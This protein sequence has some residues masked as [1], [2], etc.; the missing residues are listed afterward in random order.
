MSVLKFKKPEP[1]EPHISGQAVC[2][3]CRHHWVAVAPVGSVDL[4]CPSCE[5]MRGL[6]QYPVGAAEGDNVFQCA[7]G[8]QHFF[9]RLRADR[10]QIMCIGCGVD[11]SIDDVF[12]R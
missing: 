3:A 7:C 11:A 1:T 9:F 8:A 4:Q 5:T 2:L 10:V 6:M 12:P